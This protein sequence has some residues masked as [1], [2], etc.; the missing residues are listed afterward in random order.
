MKKGEYKQSQKEKILQQRDFLKLDGLAIIISQPSIQRFSRNVDKEILD[1]KGAYYNKKEIVLCPYRFQ[2]R[3]KAMTQEVYLWKKKNCVSLRVTAGGIGI[4]LLPKELLPEFLHMVDHLE[5]EYAMIQ[6]ELLRWYEGA[7]TEEDEF[8][9]EDIKKLMGDL[10]LELGKE[11]YMI[12]KIFSAEVLQIQISPSGVR[13][14]FETLRKLSRQNAEDIIRSLNQP[15]YNILEKIKKG[16]TTKYKPKVKSM[17]LEIESL[18]EKTKLWGVEYAYKD[19]LEFS[20]SAAMFLG[21]EDKR[22]LSREEVL[23]LAISLGKCLGIDNAERDPY[24]VF[25]NVDKLKSGELTGRERSFLNSVI[26]NM[27]IDMGE[28][29]VSNEVVYD[30]NNESK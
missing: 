26:D 11:T 14:D 15:L 7:T 5:N 9:V 20:E 1:T 4:E 18:R 16:T 2:K 24:A 30:K 25:D 8:S 3:I 13:E 28:E 17:K 12:S 19:I 27:M 29:N 23:P 21:K 10:G 22:E 6:N